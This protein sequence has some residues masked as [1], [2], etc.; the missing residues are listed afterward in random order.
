MVLPAIPRSLEQL[1]EFGR[2]LRHEVD[3]AP[4]GVIRFDMAKLAALWACLPPD[5]AEEIMC[6]A[7][8]HTFLAAAVV[9]GKFIDVMTVEE[10]QAVLQRQ[11]QER[12]ERRRH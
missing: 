12:A 6:E 3:A 2:L 1:A 10:T 4:S 11:G 8:R 7:A 5:E 9:D